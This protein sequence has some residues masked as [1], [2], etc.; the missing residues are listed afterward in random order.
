MADV[1]QAVRLAIEFAGGG[2]LPA[3]AC[4]I[5]S[6]ALDAASATAAGAMSMAARHAAFAAAAADGRG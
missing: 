1:D 4:A 3:D 2:A 5:V 6:A